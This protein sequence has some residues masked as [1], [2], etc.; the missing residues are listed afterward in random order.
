[1]RF[2]TL[3]G[4]GGVGAI[5]AAAL[6]LALVAQPGLALAQA[7]ERPHISVTGR[8][9]SEVAPDMASVSLGVTSEAEEAQEAMTETSNRVSEMLERL[10]AA[11]IEDR[12]IQTSGLSLQP[13]WHHPQRAED[14]EAR[15]T[16]FV[17]TNIVTVRVRD[18]EQLGGVLDDVVQGGANTLHGL[19]FELAEPEPAKDDARRNAVADAQRKAELYA[20]AA[21]VTLGPVISIAEPDGNDIPRP[22]FRMEAAA[23]S[24]A[25][26]VPVAQGELTLD[27]TVTVIY[28]IRD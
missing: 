18:L 11:G 8:G 2:S 4:S 10:A 22:M 23:M 21:G 26:G 25:G 9:Q 16:G 15:I 5:R 19:T 13:R 28:G 12:D 20:E 3:T 1:M 6:G 14:G 7:P 27:A 24:D 17:A